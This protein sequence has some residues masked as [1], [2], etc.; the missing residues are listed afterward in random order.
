MTV[1]SIDLAAKYSAGMLISPALVVHTQFDSSGGEDMFIE[2]L[3]NTFVLGFAAQLVVEDLPHGVEY[4]ALVKRVCQIQGR[5]AERMYGLSRLT[6]L[7]FVAPNTWR[8][9]YPV[10]KKRGQGPEAVVPVALEHGYEPPKLK[11]LEGPR[12]GRLTVNKIQTDY[13]AAF[14]IGKW[15]NDTFEERGTYDVPGTERY[16]GKTMKQEPASD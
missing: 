7:L 11:H 12:G 8:A 15:A 13:C 16:G 6:E 1:V 14:L 2:Q 3:T 9:H 4:R 5:I 10:L